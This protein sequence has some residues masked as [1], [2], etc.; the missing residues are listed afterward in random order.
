[1]LPRKEPKLENFNVDEDLN[2]HPVASGVWEK[3]TQTGQFILGAWNRFLVPRLVRIESEALAAKSAAIE[4]RKQ[5]AANKESAEAAVK[6]V[7]ERVAAIEATLAAKK[8]PADIDPIENR[9]R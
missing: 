3:L 5:A 8:V 7:A 4:V 1:M 9:G 2:F 6:A